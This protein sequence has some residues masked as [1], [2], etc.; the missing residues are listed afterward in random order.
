MATI[1]LSLGE[2]ETFVM[3]SLRVTPATS[4]LLARMSM[5]T[6]RYSGASVRHAR[7]LES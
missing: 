1:W 4:F 6:R 3:G 5:N 7:N 2:M